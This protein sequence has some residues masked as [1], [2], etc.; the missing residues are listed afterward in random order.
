M[1]TKRL[2]KNRNAERKVRNVN[3]DM[4]NEYER[5]IDDYDVIDEEA[6]VEC[7]MEDE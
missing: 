2:T 3:D 5:V 7:L 1:K 6:Y 4:A